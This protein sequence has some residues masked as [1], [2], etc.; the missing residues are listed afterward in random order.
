MNNPYETL[1]EMQNMFLRN[2]C[3]FRNTIT[4]SF[5]IYDQFDSKGSD[6]YKYPVT[7]Y[8]FNP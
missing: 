6:K 1:H 4:K 8:T 3:S 7:S 2:L 5:Q